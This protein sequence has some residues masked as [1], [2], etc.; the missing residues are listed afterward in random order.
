ML[1]LL[2]QNKIFLLLTMNQLSFSIIMV[3]L[4]Q[5]FKT[6]LFCFLCNRIF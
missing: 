3:P 2:K 1:T 4:V 5:D 6:W